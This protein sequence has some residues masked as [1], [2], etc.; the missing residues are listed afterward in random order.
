MP[1]GAGW[2]DFLEAMSALSGIF[3]ASP[4]TELAYSTG[5]N[6]LTWV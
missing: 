5:V 3:N 6:R 1:A 2:G 4:A